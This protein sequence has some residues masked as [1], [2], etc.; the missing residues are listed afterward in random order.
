MHNVLISLHPLFEVLS[1]NLLTHLLKVVFK[2]KNL[3]GVGIGDNLHII[4]K[5]L[6][7]VHVLLVSFK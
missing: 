6:V 2:Y 7:L 3:F 5:L 4:Q 1:D